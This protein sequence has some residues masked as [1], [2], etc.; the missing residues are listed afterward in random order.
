MNETTTAKKSE[1]VFRRLSESFDQ[2]ATDIVQTGIGHPI[3]KTLLAL[4]VLY[5]RERR[6]GAEE[7]RERGG[8][9]SDGGTAFGIFWGVVCSPRATASSRRAGH[10]HH[11]RPGRRGAAGMLLVMAIRLRHRQRGGLALSPVRYLSCVHLL[12]GWD[13]GRPGAGARLVFSES[14]SAR[15]RPGWFLVTYFSA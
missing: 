12:P 2:F 7:S 14:R 9:S 15:S 3:A 8:T 5:L 10:R 1:F 11:L 6:T 13:G 4:A